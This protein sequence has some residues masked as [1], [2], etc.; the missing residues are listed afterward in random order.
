MSRRVDSHV[1]HQMSSH[2]MRSHHSEKFLRK[3]TMRSTIRNNSM[4]DRN[5]VDS[6]QLY[7]Q[8]I[9][10]KQNDPLTGKTQEH[11][12]GY[13]D[14]FNSVKDRPLHLILMTEECLHKSSTTVLPIV[15]R[16]A[17]LNEANTLIKSQMCL[18]VY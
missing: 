2:C 1:R 12:E 8:V 13:P 3:S 11:M 14:F 18:F 4:T 6:I 10:R 15:S 9:V 16:L 7:S 17:L 5:Q